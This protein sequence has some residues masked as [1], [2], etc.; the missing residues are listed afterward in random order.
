MKKDTAFSISRTENNFATF[1]NREYHL[2]RIGYEISETIYNYMSILHDSF[3]SCIDKLNSKHTFFR[4]K[5]GYCKY[6]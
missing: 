4:K 1:S 6:R 5:S 2:M 3:L